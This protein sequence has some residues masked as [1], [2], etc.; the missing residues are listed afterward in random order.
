VHGNRQGVGQRRQLWLAG[1]HRA[2][3]LVVS[4]LPSIARAQTAPVP[5]IRVTFAEAIQ[6]A[7][8]NNPTVA[9]AAAGILRAEGLLQQARAATLLQVVGNV[10]STTLNTG[11]EFDGA[12]VTPQSQVTATINVA[13]PIVAA[14]AWA[15]RAQA[16]D[17]R[18][19]A[20][21]DV[22]ETRRQIAF[23]AADAYLAIIAQ[24][25]VVEGAVRARDVAKAHFDLASELEQKGT[26]S[27]LNALRAQQ[28][29]SADEGLVEVSRLALYRAQEA[30]GALIAVDGPVDAIDEPDFSSATAAPEPSPEIGRAS[31][32]ERV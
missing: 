30:L 11:V 31:C 20:E 10:T 25:R 26:G 1:R 17:T 32:R 15:R 23:S 18:T 3:A 4:L 2:L 24:R 14:A 16:A 28:Q 6:R 22:A 5:V 19:T 7:Q 13:M 27:R 21:A 9:A 12:T 29:V 8:E